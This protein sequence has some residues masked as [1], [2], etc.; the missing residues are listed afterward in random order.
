MEEEKKELYM[1]NGLR[2]KK[3][4]FP[5]YTKDELIPTII[6]CMLF[7]MIDCILFI[8]G[9]RNVGLLFFIPLIGTST[10][11]FSLIKGEL[12]L[13]PIDV[14]K[15]EIAFAQSQKYY[16]YIAKQEWSKYEEES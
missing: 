16:P 2:M 14:L 4:F 7:I 10:V 6:S 15:Q 8:C 12:N 5:G 13:S 9:N 11:A 3:E 1:P